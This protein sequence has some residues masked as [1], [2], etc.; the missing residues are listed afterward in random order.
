MKLKFYFIQLAI[1]QFEYKNNERTTENLC[2][3]W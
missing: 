2:Y 1:N 3:G